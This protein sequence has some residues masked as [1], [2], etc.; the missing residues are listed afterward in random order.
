MLYKWINYMNK[1]KS[2]WNFLDFKLNSVSVS[3]LLCAKN[4]WNFSV[5]IIFP[6]NVTIFQTSPRFDFKSSI[7]FFLNTSK[8]P[9]LP[10]PSPL[11]WSKLSVLTWPSAPIPSPEGHPVNVRPARSD[12]LASAGFVLRTNEPLP[13]CLKCW[14]QRKT[15]PAVVCQSWPKGIKQSVISLVAWLP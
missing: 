10:H 5:K 14:R 2:A 7:N 15:W 12:P 9:S 4:L 3:L 13:K 11:R 1:R 8:T 6:V